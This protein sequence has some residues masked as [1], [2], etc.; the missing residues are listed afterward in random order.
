MLACQRAS[1][2]TLNPQ[3]LAIYSHLCVRWGL[4][5]DCDAIQ[6]SEDRLGEDGKLRRARFLSGDCPLS[7]ATQLDAFHLV[8]SRNWTTCSRGLY[9]G[10]DASQLY[11]AAISR[12]TCLLQDFKTT[13]GTVDFPMLVKAFAKGDMGDIGPPSGFLDRV[14]ER[15][16]V[17]E[18][19]IVKD[20]KNMTQ[21]E[22][23]GQWSAKNYK[24]MTPEEFVKCWA[25]QGVFGCVTQEAN[26]VARSS[27]SDNSCILKYTFSR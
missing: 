19:Y 12:T 14:V 24:S 13:N 8:S 17:R 7:P 23:L 18:Q 6:D 2:A 16:A 11:A 3:Q 4:L 26:D 20:R 22:S 15:C 5:A 25:G 27:P 9:T 21:E 1:S 10:D